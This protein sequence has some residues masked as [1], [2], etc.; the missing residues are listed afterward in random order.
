MMQI[1][2]LGEEGKLLMWIN[3]K[4]KEKPHFGFRSK[5]VC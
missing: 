3:T 1:L 4:T 2:G 5:K